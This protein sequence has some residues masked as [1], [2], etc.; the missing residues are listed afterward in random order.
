MVEYDHHA[1][2]AMLDQYED[3]VVI[4]GSFFLASSFITLLTH[5]I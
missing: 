2:L 5:E 4:T 3:D 1:I